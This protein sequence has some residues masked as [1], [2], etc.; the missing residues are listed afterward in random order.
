MTHTAAED[1]P[2][3]GAF[4]CPSGLRSLVEQVGT[5]AA[6]DFAGRFVR[7]W[8][9]RCARLHLAVERCDGADGRD[10]ALSLVSSAT[11]AGAHRLAELG[12][13]L[14]A[15]MPATARPA[16][17][18]RAAELID[19]LDRLGGLSVAEVARLAREICPGG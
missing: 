5:T 3:A 6:S 18:S 9:V 2:T 12:S 19:E 7:L 14:H 16:D 13:L 1:A 10:A 11:L 8:P 4:V 17:W 15:R